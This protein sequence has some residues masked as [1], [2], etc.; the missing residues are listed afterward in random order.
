MLLTLT[1]LARPMTVTAALLSA[2]LAG[3]PLQVL[4]QDYSSGWQAEMDL[5]SAG[6]ASSIVLHYRCAGSAEGEASAVRAVER[7]QAHVQR[8]SSAA[9][10]VEL[11]QYVFDS[12]NR[13]LAAMTQSTEGQSCSQLLRLR[14]IAF[15][16]G[17]SL[18]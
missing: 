2:L 14:D 8:L 17:F 3:A 1:R 12:A 13:K 6:A 11:R 10:E 16:T 5:V 15:G 9:A 7:M 18:P 4:A